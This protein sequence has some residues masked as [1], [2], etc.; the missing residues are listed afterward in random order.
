[1]ARC[2]RCGNYFGTPLG[3]GQDHDC[4]WCGLRPEDVWPVY[5][6]PP[7]DEEEAAEAAKENKHEPS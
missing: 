1:M 5:D 4:P 7:E 6:D 2:G 3:E